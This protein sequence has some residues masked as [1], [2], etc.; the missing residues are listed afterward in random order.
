MGNTSYKQKQRLAKHILRLHKEERK[1]VA[2]A[3]DKK[4]TNYVIIIVVAALSIL[5]TSYITFGIK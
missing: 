4:K 1:R 5:V 2:A 3:A